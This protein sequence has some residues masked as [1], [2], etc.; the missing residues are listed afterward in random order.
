MVY[1]QSSKSKSGSKSKRSQER[2]SNGFR[3]YVQALG[4]CWSSLVLDGGVG[5]LLVPEVRVARARARVVDD[6]GLRVVRALGHGL[7]VVRAVLVD[8]PTALDIVLDH[9]RGEASGAD[10][11]AVG[12]GVVGVLVRGRGGRVALVPA[13]LDATSG[14]RTAHERRRQESSTASSNDEPNSLAD[15]GVLAGHGG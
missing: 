14:V 10:G 15:L 2:G 11:V 8:G 6:R 1:V 13:V 4:R 12:L 5:V 3:S 9:A 7:V